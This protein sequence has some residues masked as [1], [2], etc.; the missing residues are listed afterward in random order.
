MFLEASFRGSS[1]FYG[2]VY[3]TLFAYFHASAWP[4]CPPMVMCPGKERYS[5]CNDDNIQLIVLSIAAPSSV[6]CRLDPS[7]V[8]V[9]LIHY[10]VRVV[11]IDQ[12]F[13]LTQCRIGQI[14]LCLS[15]DQIKSPLEPLMLRTLNLTSLIWE[16]NDQISPVAM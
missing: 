8:A 1:M 11:I 6:S 13:H 15:N 10:G 9:C 2:V 14:Q 7:S 12:Y 5:Y 16:R 3:R 4:Q